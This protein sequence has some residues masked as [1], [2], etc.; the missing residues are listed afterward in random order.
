MECN[1]M[2][3]KLIIL[4]L[5]LGSLGTF[6]QEIPPVLSNFRVEAN[7]KSR[8]YF[9]SSQPISGKSVAGFK[10]SDRAIIGL[11]LN[12]STTGHYFTVSKDFSFWDNNTIRY[13]GGSDMINENSIPIQEYS[14]EFID[15]NISE[16]DSNNRNIYVSTS[17]N[18]NNSGTSQNQAWRTIS[19]ALNV[20][21]PGTTIWIK[22]GDY[23]NEKLKL[24]KSGLENNPIKIIGYKDTPGDV[25]SNYYNYG[26]IMDS[27]EMPTLVGRSLE[28]DDMF[29]L[30]GVEYIII[31]NFQIQNANYGI[32][33][34]TKGKSCNN[35]VIDNYNGYK[36]GNK[37]NEH[38]SALSFQTTNG[39]TFVGS[40]NIRIKNSVIVNSSMHNLVIFG[41]GN[42]MID[43]VKTYNDRIDIDERSDYQI[44][45]NGDN[46]IITNCYS[47]N[48]NKTETNV[49]THGIGIR[50]QNRGSNRF[51]LITNCEVVNMQEG[52]YIRN[53]GCENNVIKNSVVRNNGSSSYEDR[54]GVVIWGGSNNNIIES[55]NVFDVDFGIIFKDNQEDESSDTSIGQNNLIRNCNFFRTKYSIR[56]SGSNN[57]LLKDNKIYNCNFFESDI[58]FRED[59][60]LVSNLDIKN[61]NIIKVKK[62]THNS[63]INGL[64]FS[65]TNFFQSWGKE[66]GEGNISS[67]PKFEDSKSGNFR[68]KTDSEVINKGKNLKEVKR[69][70]DGIPRPQGNSL[71]IGS[72]EFIDKST[73][74]VNANAGNDQTIC[75]GDEIILVA[76]GGS[77][78]LWNTGETTK[79]IKVSPLSTIVYTVVVNMG[80]ISDSDDVTINVIDIQ[81]NAG[82]DI[83]I[84]KGEEITLT[85]TNADNYVWSNG[86][87]GNTI[88]VSPEETTV[89]FVATSEGDC[90]ITD[91]VTVT[92]IDIDQTEPSSL[93]ADAGIDRTIC[94]GESI[95]LTASG[96]LTYLWSN[97]E[98]TK[99]IQVSPTESTKY[100]VTASEGLNSDT[101]EVQVQV[102]SVQANAG[103]DVSISQGESVKLSAS[104]GIN[105]LWSNGAKTKSIDVQP[106]ATKVFSVQVINGNCIDEDE[107]EVK[108]L[109]QVLNPDR[110][111][112]DAGENQTICFG[113]SATINVQGAVDYQ[114]STGQIGEQITVI[115]LRTETYEVS[116]LINGEKIS[117]TITITVE[118]CSSNVE[119]ENKDGDLIVQLYPNPTSG[120]IKIQSSSLRSEMDMHLI[121]MNGKVLYEETLRVEQGSFGKQLDLSNYTK[122][123]Y[124]LR[125]LDEEEQLVKKIVLI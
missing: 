97:G 99:S 29:W 113:E 28:N 39:N 51:N 93:A 83:S 6:A 87:V 19:K 79:Q 96:G 3:I 114:W 105:Y 120:I 95:V 118:N 69:D 119:K 58:F 89:Y 88:K 91:Q 73:G 66:K 122:G 84:D 4:Y 55:V 42:N 115:P 41:D 111:T 109:Q 62:A 100:S 64:N 101:D 21:N 82:Q 61:C 85:A 35:I 52:L 31:R 75:K 103:N 102:V 121:D 13:E 74:S 53:I 45:L 68:L 71:D 116:T 63:T 9:D 18:D 50:G 36:F 125:F 110:F 92:V 7:Q 86:T 98:D 24:N 60:T 107:V 76:S 25:L 90:Q 1:A 78:Y 123:I 26:M 43:N 57:S 12:T 117:D 77:S 15:N 38:A 8:V 46:N 106:S 104:G 22:S 14:L 23:G 37:A 56:S 20:V 112:I 67:D 59:K 70:F 81:V 108:V 10:I 5:F 2:K 40:E 49:S 47:E 124:F 32:R 44:S 16:P 34:G 94:Q 33:S 30:F 27:A 65:F 11:K 17:G 72:Y 48:F 80:G 54:G